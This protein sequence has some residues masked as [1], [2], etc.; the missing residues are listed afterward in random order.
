MATAIE[1]FQRTLLQPVSEPARGATQD[2]IERT[3]AARIQSRAEAAFTAYVEAKQPALDALPKGDVNARI[4]EMNRRNVEIAGDGSAQRWA[5]QDANDFRQIRSEV[6]REEVAITIAGNPSTA[7]KDALQRAAPDVA[8]SVAA[9][10]RE[11]D[12]Q[13]LNKEARKAHDLP[14]QSDRNVISADQAERNAR[15]YLVQPRNK[16][17]LTHPEL[18]PAYALED[19]LRAEAAQARPISSDVARR[20]VATIRQVVAARIEG[21]Q[22]LDANAATRTAVRYEV[23]LASLQQ[24]AQDKQLGRQSPPLAS[25]HRRIVTERAEAAMQAGPGAAQG[26]LGARSVA[27]SLA[28]VDAPANQHPFLERV[29]AQVYEREQQRLA[30]RQAEPK[31]L[32]RGQER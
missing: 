31:D 28:T 8:A 26:M 7:Y 20:V 14:P 11:N 16:A 2:S 29:L 5:E 21:N 22:V 9:Y 23:A 12:R 25:E 15:A 4:A 32:G 6:R 19:S 10:D 18:R 30:Q 24:A 27:I 17:L 13:V 3:A 1:N